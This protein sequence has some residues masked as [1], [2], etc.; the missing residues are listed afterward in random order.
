MQP[1]FDDLMLQKSELIKKLVSFVLTDTILYLPEDESICTK[2]GQVNLLLGT[3]FV[4][5]K[6]IDVPAE[7]VAQQ[8]K[9]E[10]YL[11]ECST[12]KTAFIYLMATEIRS[13]LLAILWMEEKIDIDE[14]FLCAFFEELQEQKQWGEIEEIIERNKLIKSKLNDLKKWRNE[15]SLSKN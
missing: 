10:K 9:V 2:L 11:L 12:E 1:W 5:V 6:G 3:D 7:N 8:G 14:L 15:R 4:L 13:V